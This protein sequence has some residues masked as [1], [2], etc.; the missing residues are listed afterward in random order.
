LFFDGY[1]EAMAIAVTPLKSLQA[2]SNGRL[3]AFGS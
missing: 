2:R 3:I 1:I